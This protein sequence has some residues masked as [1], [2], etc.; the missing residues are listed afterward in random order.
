LLEES[1]PQFAN[2]LRRI[3]I[4][5]IPILTINSV[6]FTTNDSVLYN[7]V[8]AHRMGMIP[9]VFNPK[10]FEFKDGEEST[11][12][13]EVVFAINKKGPGMVYS[14]DMKSSNPEVKP[15]HDN[16]PIVELFGD[17]KLKL[18]ANATLGLGINHARYQG[19]NTFYRYF[20]SVKVDGKI[21][22]IDEVIRSC[23]KGAI[24]FKDNKMI[25]KTDCDI[26]KECIK[27]AK[28]K[29]ALDIIGDDTKF[30]FTVESISGLKPEQITLLSVDIL[31]KKVK[32]FA[33][34]VKK[35]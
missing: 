2:A 11:S 3:M 16:I 26:C 9:L 25:I 12:S 6:D 34:E 14:K 13:N 15:L 5:E 29:G 22:N 28:P 19:A 17:Q 32:D 7:E 27:I 18:E 20:A 30:I 4:G 23:P 24:D 31:K 1:N 35:L 21:V 8:I 33:K 10:D